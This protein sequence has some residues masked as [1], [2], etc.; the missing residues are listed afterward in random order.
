MPLPN[1]QPS[2]RS[3]FARPVIGSVTLCLIVTFYI[4]IVTNRTFWLKSYAYLS[5]SPWAFITFIV[6]IAAICMA[7][8]TL[9]TLK[10]LTK[11]ALIFFV[12]SASA[13]SW[14]TDHFGTIIDNDMIRNAAD[15]TG[16]EAGHLVTVR[17]I[18][19][20]FATGIVPS[21]LI[22]WVRLRHRPIFS[23]IAYNAMVIIPC[24]LIFL[25]V[26]I[27]HYKTFSSV[28]RQHRDMM[29]TF[30]PFLPIGNAVNFAVT[31]AR[32]RNVVLQ[33]VGTD[34]H[35]VL[36]ADAPVKPR[37]LIVVA[38]ET[39]RAHDFSLNGYEQE[40]NPELKKQNIIYFPNTV[41]C[42]TSTAVSIPCIFSRFPRTEFTHRKGVANENLLDVL[43]HAGIKS[44]WLD[45]DT[46]S[47]KV[48]ARVPYEALPKSNDPR[49]CKNGECL[50]GILL[51][52]VDG[53]LDKVHGDSVLVL[54][55]L[56]SHGPAYYQRYPQEFRKFTP[57]CR[58]NDFSTCSQQ[59][60]VNAYDNS[61][62]YTD[63]IVS[64]VIDKLKARSAE[65][66]GAVVYFSDH[67][68]SL[69]ENGIYLHGAPYFIA[70]DYQTHVPMLYW[71]SNDFARADRTDLACAAKQTSAPSSHDN[72]FHSVLGIMAVKTNVY[73]PA[74]DLFSKCRTAAPN[75]ASSN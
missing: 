31:D 36:A 57:D 55:Q 3:R 54:H 63:H 52:K 28:V 70:P 25:G 56:G 1:D 6:G 9:P 43:A 49:F 2:R 33:P 46:G 27:G 26:A 14:F 16:A 73:D 42:G 64:S 53:W 5:D 45:N 8:I 50:D 22:V 35:V 48:A 29:A 18:L 30:N 44:T 24:L 13:A 62:L 39:A 68:E 75:V 32:D 67:G 4:L 17:F 47:Y 74:L 10:Y 40:T 59:E 61:I 60:I 37:V 65:F 66:S 7:I 58:A 41:S 72:F 23:K 38:G 21:L 51:D 20:F 34:A 12:L 15:T 71:L 69:G 19:Y 11:P